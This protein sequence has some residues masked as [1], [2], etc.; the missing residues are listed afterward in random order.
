MRTALPRCLLNDLHLDVFDELIV[1]MVLPVFVELDR[2]VVQFC[3]HNGADRSRTVEDLLDLFKGTTSR[4][5][6]AA[7]LR[8]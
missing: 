2:L 7:S 1:L 3:F 4:F 5:R 8:Q 6:V